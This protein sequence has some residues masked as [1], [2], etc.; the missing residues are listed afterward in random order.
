[1]DLFQMDCVALNDNLY[2]LTIPQPQHLLYMI[3]LHFIL[4]MTSCTDKLTLNIE[5]IQLKHITL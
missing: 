2:M 3:T 1:M 4:C 5:F